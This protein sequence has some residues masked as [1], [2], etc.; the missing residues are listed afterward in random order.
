MRAKLNLF[1]TSPASRVADKRHI[2]GPCGRSERSGKGKGDAFGFCRGANPS[3]LAPPQP[4]QGQR[5]CP[6]NNKT[7]SQIFSWPG[8]TFG[9]DSKKDRRAEQHTG[10]MVWICGSLVQKTASGDRSALWES[11]SLDLG[12]TE[13]PAEPPNLV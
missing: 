9:A 13:E 10:I 2:P 5:Y 1:K 3:A 4:H 12:V 6:H 11:C 8:E 7:P